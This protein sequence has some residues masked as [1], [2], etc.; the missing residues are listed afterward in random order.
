MTIKSLKAD[1]LKLLFGS[2]GFDSGHFM[3]EWENDYGNTHDPYPSE[4]ISRIL[5]L[6]NNAVIC[7]IGAGYG[8]VLSGFPDNFKL[9]GL[10]PN[11][12]LYN[13]MKKVQRI[14]SLNLKARE[15][16]D[17]LNVNV[18][19]SIRALHYIG[20]IELGILLLRIKRSYPE[21]T[22]I[23]WERKDTCRRVRLVNSFIRFSRC[24]YQELIN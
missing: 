23:I 18:F 5:M 24:F 9:I 21:S 2:G 4:V 6:S 19:F 20:V 15:L 16:P 10:E 14:H 13:A 11:Q 22:L 8:R 3:F 1:A 7:E 17:D 12:M